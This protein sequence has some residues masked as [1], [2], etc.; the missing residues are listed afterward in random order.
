MGRVSVLWFVVLIVMVCY[1]YCYGLLCL[2]L[3]FVMLI[4]VYCKY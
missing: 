3:W 2:L 1:V 4:V